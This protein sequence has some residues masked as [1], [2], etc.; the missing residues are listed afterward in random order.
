MGDAYSN[1]KDVISNGFY[2]KVKCPCGKDAVTDEGYCAKCT[3]RRVADE[4]I[5]NNRCHLTNKEVSDG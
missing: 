4:I 3:G 5:K 2:P 1:S